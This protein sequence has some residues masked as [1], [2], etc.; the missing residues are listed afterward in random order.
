MQST[1]QIRYAGAADVAAVAAI[2][3]NVVRPLEIYCQSARDG[4]IEKFSEEE[5][6]RRVT[7]DA[8]AVA[9]AYL[10]T[11]VAG[12]SI[13]DDQH[14]PIWI[15]WYGVAP[16]MRG[17]GVGRALLAHLIDEA[18]KRNATK[19]WCDTRVNNVPSMELFKQIGFAKLCELKNHWY[20]QDFYL[21]ERSI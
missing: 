16:E 8:K 4:E 19:L 9:L 7:L 17:K 3:K 15:E 18:P 21:W 10:G 13:T 11:E 20:G 6:R 1:I 14:G 12:F 5:L 2:F